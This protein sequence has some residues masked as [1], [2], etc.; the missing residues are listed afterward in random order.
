MD[1]VLSSRGLVSRL[2]DFL[3]RFR[4]DRRHVISSPPLDVFQQEINQIEKVLADTRPSRIVRQAASPESLTE[5]QKIMDL[6][7]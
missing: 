1:S 7:G 5:Q 2:I 3:D 4:Q 6:A